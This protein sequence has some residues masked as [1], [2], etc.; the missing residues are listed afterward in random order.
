M[1]GTSTSQ[2]SVLWSSTGYRYLVGTRSTSTVLLD[3]LVRYCIYCVYCTTAVPYR[4]RYV[5]QTASGL[6]I[7]PITPG[8]AVVVGSMYSCILTEYCTAVLDLDLQLSV[9]LS[10]ACFLTPGLAYSQK[11]MRPESHEFA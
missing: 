11:L 1:G 10:H 8:H 6:G 2:Q 3:L 7:P 9:D 5:E 4:Y